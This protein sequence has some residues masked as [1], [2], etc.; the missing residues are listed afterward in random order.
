MAS[1]VT[2]SAAITRSPSFSLSSSST[3]M[4]IFPC[5]ISSMASVIVLRLI[6]EPFYL[7]FN[8][9]QIALYPFKP[10]CHRIREMDVIQHRLRKTP[11]PLFDHSPSNTYH[12]GIPRDRFQYHRIG[13]NLYI[14]SYKDIPQDLCPNTYYNIIP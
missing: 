2:F 11:S 10:V 5:L 12:S 1:G 7:V 14:V 4:T 13:P 6:F 3:R 9:F 8:L